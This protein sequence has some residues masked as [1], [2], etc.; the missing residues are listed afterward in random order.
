MVLLSPSIRGL[1]RLLAVCEQYARS[2]G[3]KYNV[4]KTK[5]MVFKSGRG[6]TNVP[7][8]YLDEVQVERVKGFRYLG[9]MLTE[10][11]LD[12]DDI[13]R[14]RRAL[15]VRCNMLARRFARCS[16]EVKVTLFRAYCLCFYTCQLW[17]RFTRRAM[18]KIRVQ[19]N[20]AYR[21][22]MKLP[23]NCSAS[24]MFA[25]AEVPDFFAIIRSRVASFWSRLRTSDN[26]ILREL[27]GYLDNPI[28][29]YWISV[30]RER[31][32]K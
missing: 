18:N 2:H 12:D 11:L 28:S 24:T 32:R 6:P 14:E 26:S 17:S 5:M 15:A 27:S 16:D 4:L 20:D 8:V 21:I 30:H 31:N 23:R 10:G 19:Y 3:L 1:R 22:L 29:K 25:E 7:P 9:H 13:E